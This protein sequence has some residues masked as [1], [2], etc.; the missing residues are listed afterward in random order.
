MMGSMPETYLQVF[1]QQLHVM[2]ESM[3]AVSFTDMSD[4]VQNL[5]SLK[6]IQALGN[7]IAIITTFVTLTKRKLLQAITSTA[8]LIGA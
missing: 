3:T 1:S 7:K 5:E 8:S 6:E 2:G 4:Y